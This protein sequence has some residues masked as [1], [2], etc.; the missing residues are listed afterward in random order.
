MGEFLLF[1]LIFFLSP[2]SL[3]LRLWGTVG[4]VVTVW[5]SLSLRRVFPLWQSTQTWLNPTWGLRKSLNH[6]L[7]PV[8][9]LLV[10]QR[11]ILLLSSCSF[12]AQ[13]TWGSSQ[14]CFLYVSS[15]FVM[16]FLRGNK[17]RCKWGNHWTYSVINL[18]KSNQIT[19]IVTSSQHMCLDE[20]NSWE[21]APD[22]AETINI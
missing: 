15:L 9:V 18:I 6:S 1:S 11:R 8:F 21:R 4:C 7:S 20:W 12:T 19:F 5:T 16:F 2:L 22:S 10:L 17:K 3:S 14:L 13:E